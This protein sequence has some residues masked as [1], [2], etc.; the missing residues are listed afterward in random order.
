MRQVLV[1][2]AQAVAEPSTQAGPP[3]NLAAGL[4]VSDRRI[5]IDRF[6]ERAVD[7][8][9][10]LGDLGGVRQQL[11]NP[12]ASSLLSCLVNLYLLGHSGNPFF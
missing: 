7:N 12:N 3:W 5:V 1:H 6:G 8:T 9:Q 11:A 4:N 10:F 2:A